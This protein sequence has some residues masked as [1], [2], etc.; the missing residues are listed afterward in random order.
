MLRTRSMTYI[1]LRTSG[2]A[3]CS[4]ILVLYRVHFV[5]EYLHSKYCIVVLEYY[6][7]V[8]LDG[9]STQDMTWLG[10]ETPKCT[11]S[12]TP[13]SLDYNSSFV[14]TSD[15]SI[16]RQRDQL[17]HGIS[18]SLRS[19]HDFHVFDSQVGSSRKSNC[20]PSG[21]RDCVRSRSL[22]QVLDGHNDAFWIDG[23]LHHGI[24]S[25]NQMGG[26]LL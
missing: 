25:A 8:V 11:S 6:F 24:H 21:W 4:I 16:R 20:F 18:Y 9:T 12:S 5:P 7:T 13:S 3:D 2:T 17:D 23:I 1:I 22:S 15:I 14:L 10:E 19:N 26:E